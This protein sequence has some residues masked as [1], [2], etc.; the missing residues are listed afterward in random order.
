MK[1]KLKTFNEALRTFVKTHLTTIS[2]WLLVFIGVQATSVGA[3]LSRQ[4]LTPPTKQTPSNR[5]EYCQ[6]N[7][8]VHEIK[9]FQDPYSPT[10]TQ[11]K[12]LR[13]SFIGITSGTSAMSC[14]EMITPS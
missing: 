12:D 3:V 11:T 9:N 6:D 2:K 14:A 1:Q 5:L 10:Q 13:I 8:L 7:N 4:Y